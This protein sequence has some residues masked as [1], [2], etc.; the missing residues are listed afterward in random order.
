MAESQEIKVGQI[1]VEKKQRQEYGDVR[2]LRVDAVG[3]RLLSHQPGNDEITPIT[4]AIAWPIGRVAQIF[5]HSRRTMYA[6]GLRKN[7]RLEKDV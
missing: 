6:F 1:W 4:F 7:W 3:S 5:K 2:R